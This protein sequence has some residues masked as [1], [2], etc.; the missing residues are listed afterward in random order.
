MRKFTR[1]LAAAAA[2]SLVIAAC[3]G[4]DDDTDSSD[5]EAPAGTGGAETTAAAGGGGGEGK[6]VGL[7]FDI[8]GRGDKSFND[9]AAEGLDQ[10]VKDFGITAS[11]STPTGDSDRAD[12]LNLIVSEG[13]GLVIGVGFLWTDAVNAGAA[14]NPDTLF[15]LVDSVPSNNNGTPDDTADDADF[16]NGAG[17]VFAE[18][19]GSFL[20]GAA[21]AL[22]SQSGKIGFVG[23]V[24]MDLIKKFEA[25]YVAGAKA[26]NPDIEIL[27]QYVSQPP[28]FNGFNDSAKGKEI[29]AA[30]YADGADVVYHAAGATGLGVFEAAKEAGE[31]GSVWAIGVDSDQYNQVSADL[32]P[33]ILTSMLKRVNV[34]VYETIKSYVEDTFTPGVRVFDL[35]ADGVGYSTTGGFV[36]DIKAELDGYAEQ[37][38]SGEIVVPTTP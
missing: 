26:V 9:S 10:A 13:N 23:G 27:S 33:Y 20:V 2:F 4:D 16:P 6:T 7:L 36:D 38:K 19:Q 15:A 8:T 30:M 29:A 3:G 14:A 17:L 21:A 18:E 12:R 5:T 22:K 1:V 31:P 28:D 24:E 25:G 35:A 37:I 34:A 11:E 32:Q